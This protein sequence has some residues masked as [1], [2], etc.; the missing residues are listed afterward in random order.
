MGRMNGK[1]VLVTGAGTGIG[2]AVAI[3]LAKDSAIVGIHYFR[4]ADTARETAD[5]VAKLGTKAEI[6]QADLTKPDQA[7][8]LVDDFVAWAGGLDSLINNAGDIVGRQRLGEMD[9]DFLRYVMVVNVDS[10]VMVTQ[11]ALPHLRE[12][13]KNG[14]ASIVNMSSLAGRLAGGDGAG[15]YCAAKGAVVAWTKNLAK[16]LGP[17]GIRVNAVAPGMILDTHFHERHTPADV[18]KK[19]IETTPVRRAG[20]PEDVARAMVFLAAEYDGFINGAIID[21]NGG[22]W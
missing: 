6:F 20:V 13:A 14:G 5:Q 2:R 10:A 19:V 22:V 4:S 1:R 18:Q 9:L 15:A 21:I 3:E 12:S 7:K 11:A 17:D 16:E 8:R